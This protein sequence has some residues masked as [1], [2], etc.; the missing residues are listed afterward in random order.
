MKG[1]LPR[2]ARG[3]ECGHPVWRRLS[4]RKVKTSITVSQWRRHARLRKEGLPCFA[5]CRMHMCGW[6]QALVS[7]GEGSCP[8]DSTARLMASNAWQS[9]WVPVPA[10]CRKGVY[11]I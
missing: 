4:D 5:K 2:R 1:R 10:S 3:V 7:L 8:R 6:T 9:A 11:N